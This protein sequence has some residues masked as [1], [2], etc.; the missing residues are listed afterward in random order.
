MLS[1]LPPQQL[2]RAGSLTAAR[3]RHKATSAEIQTSSSKCRSCWS[4]CH[5]NRDGISRIPNNSITQ[6]PPLECTS[7]RPEPVS[8]TPTARGGH[9]DRS[10]PAPHPIS[11]GDRTGGADT[12]T[13]RAAGPNSRIKIT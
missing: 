11:S 1:E 7:M 6:A 2:V 5:G 12:E 9:Q 13:P 3:P 8:G 10:S 4:G